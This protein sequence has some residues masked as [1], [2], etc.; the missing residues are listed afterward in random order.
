MLQKHCIRLAVICLHY[1]DIQH[2]RFTCSECRNTAYKL[3][4]KCWKYTQR[5]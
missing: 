3:S 5:L 4:T 2:F 1:S